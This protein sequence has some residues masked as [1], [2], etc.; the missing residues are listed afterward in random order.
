MHCC[1]QLRMPRPQSLCGTFQILP[2][3]ARAISQ[4]RKTSREV[5]SGSVA[6]ARLC[7]GSEFARVLDF[8]WFVPKRV[9]YCLAAKIKKA[10]KPQ[11]G[12]HML[13]LR[14]ADFRS[15]VRRWRS[16]A[17]VA[18]IAFWSQGGR[19]GFPRTLKSIW[20]LVAV[21]QSQRQSS[22]ASRHYAL[23]NDSDLV[24]FF[25]GTRMAATC[26]VRLRLGSFS[27]DGKCAAHNGGK[28][29]P[30]PPRNTALPRGVL[31][32]VCPTVSGLLHSLRC[33]RLL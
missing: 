29:H 13:A 1:K 28:G 4:Q 11:S 23:R 33:Q 17:K 16:A 21:F 26:R 18:C 14:M 25:H 15:S 27:R 32:C 7:H 20:R 2:P 31:V 30:I 6:P 10:P 3:F 19:H 12:P 9:V 22:A 24:I 5:S 8:L